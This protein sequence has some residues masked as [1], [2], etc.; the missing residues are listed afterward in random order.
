MTQT[1]AYKTS[2]TNTKQTPSHHPISFYKGLSLGRAP[3]WMALEWSDDEALKK[4]IYSEKYDLNE[5]DKITGQT[6]AMKL[7]QKGK[8]DLLKDVVIGGAN[9]SIRD[10]NGKN[11]LNY[12]F[13]MYNNYT[14]KN[15]QS[16]NKVCFYPASKETYKEIYHFIRQEY[17]S[18]KRLTDFRQTAIIALLSVTPKTWHEQ[19]IRKIYKPQKLN[20]FKNKKEYNVPR[21]ISSQNV[22]KNHQQSTRDKER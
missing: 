14:Q 20:T 19:I 3:F 4:I 1:L 18:A 22:L 16:I 21:Q 8:L 12:A 17:K 10:Y 13:E 7:I 6:L 2:D 5:Q 9:V 11:A 15:E